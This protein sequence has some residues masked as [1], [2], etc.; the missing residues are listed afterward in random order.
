M[1]TIIKKITNDLENDKLIISEAG[2]IIREGGLVA[3]PTETVYGLGGDAF[4]P[5]AAAKIYAAKGRP[6]DNPLIVHIAKVEDL[7]ALSD[8]V[9]QAAYMLADKFWPGPLTIIVKKN[10]RVPMSVTGGLNTV[11]V[12]LPAN[13]IARGIIEESQTFIAAPSANLSGRPS[14]TTGEHVIEDLSG[15]VDM[16][17]DGGTIDIGLESTIVDLS[18]TIPVVLRP[19]FITV[20]ELREVIGEV[21]I[22]PAIKGTLKED[23][24]PKAPGMKYRHYAP[25]AL[26]TIV[27]GEEK[28]VVDKLLQLLKEDVEKG[29]KVGIMTTVKHKGLFDKGEV[30]CLGE[31]DNNE[32]IAR[33]LFW[34]LR[35]F[36]ELNVDVIYS[37]AFSEEGVGQ[38][39][40]NR[41]NKAAG[42]RTI[43]VK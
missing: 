26:L 22:D 25:K 3:F 38:A 1:E 31:A 4:S 15:R 20:E 27:K 30:I 32:E 40:M 34:A 9:P 16:I 33:N 12:R 36:D 24:A 41:L 39:V 42:H 8:E 10:D 11:A 29:L 2:R 23:V 18:E 14:P 37:E 7:K 17:V 21:V 13:T 5:D 6:S 43:L 35:R 19:G 28:K